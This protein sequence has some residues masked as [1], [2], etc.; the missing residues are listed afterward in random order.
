M[1]VALYGAYP[2][3]SEAVADQRS[4]SEENELPIPLYLFIPIASD[5]TDPPL[6]GSGGSGEPRRRTKSTSQDH[7][8]RG[9]R[10]IRLMQ[11]V[12]VFSVALVAQLRDTPHI[13]CW[14]AVES[15]L[16]FQRG[17]ALASSRGALLVGARVRP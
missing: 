14:P 17:A 4:F 5:G 12:S 8:G 3:H 6:A 11:I 2:W 9:R 1:T 16:H 7:D 10:S 13:G 15:L